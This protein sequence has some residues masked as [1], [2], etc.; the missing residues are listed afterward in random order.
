MTAH[1]RAA[2][3]PRLEG[4]EP[5][6]DPSILQVRVPQEALL[7]P[8][9]AVGGTDQ[10]HERTVQQMSVLLQCLPGQRM[11]I[12]KHGVKSHGSGSIFVR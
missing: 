5:P 6:H 1:H 10:L 9:E 8:D 4:A 12:L 3:K 7:E 11:T 2:R